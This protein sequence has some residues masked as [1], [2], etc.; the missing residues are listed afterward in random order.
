MRSQIEPAEPPGK[1]LISGGASH[2]VRDRGRWRRRLLHQHEPRSLQV[3]HKPI[4][5]DPGHRVV[6]MVNALSPFELQCE[7]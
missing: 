4:G 5:R 7:G 1:D 2:M 6:R 3:P